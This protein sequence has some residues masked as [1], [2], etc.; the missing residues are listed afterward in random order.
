MERPP[1]AFAEPDYLLA[2]LTRYRVG[3]PA[4]WALLPRSINEAREAYAWMAAQRSNEAPVR[5]FI[6]GGGS[7]VLISDQGLDGVVLITAA[8]E[9][10]EPLGD[11]R[12]RIECGVELNDLVHDVLLPGNYD[13]VGGLTGIPGTVGGA[14]Y[15]NAGTVNGTTCQWVESVEVAGAGGTRAVAMAPSLYEY[16]SQSFCPPGDLILQ[17]IFQFRVAEADQQAVYEHYLQRRREKQPQGN[18][19]GS[20]FKNP[21]HGHAGRLIEACGLKGTRRGGALISPVHANFIMNDG[22]ATFDDIRSLIRLCQ[23][24][25][26]QRFGVDLEREVVVLD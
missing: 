12:F 1:F 18:C 10:M 9:G 13:G 20:V 22:G 17:G 11:D 23:S 26:K 19:C 2:P 25:V 4:R 24:T 15:M 14:I 5:R 6:L 8:L 3:G 7:N 21:P 16:R